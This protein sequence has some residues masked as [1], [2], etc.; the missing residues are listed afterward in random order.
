MIE[1]VV[2]HEKRGDTRVPHAPRS[3]KQIGRNQIAGS[4]R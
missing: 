4:Y 2:K 3:P 1:E